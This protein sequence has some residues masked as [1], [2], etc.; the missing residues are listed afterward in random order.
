[1]E[2]ILKRDDFLKLLVRTVPKI[3]CKDNK[4]AEQAI[5]RFAMECF[6]QGIELERNG[7]IEIQL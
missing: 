3:L 6:D 2:T 4:E 1:M 5:I 7:K